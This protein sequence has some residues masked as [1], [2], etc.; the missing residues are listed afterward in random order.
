MLCADSSADSR[1]GREA[2]RIKYYVANPALVGQQQH[3][4]PPAFGPLLKGSALPQAQMNQTFKGVKEVE[5]SC[6]V[7]NASHAGSDGKQ[8][9]HGSERKR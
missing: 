4:W 9:R 2:W 1:E 3:A 7:L 5:E 8:G 6:P